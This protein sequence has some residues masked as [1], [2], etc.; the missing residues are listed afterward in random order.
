MKIWSVVIKQETLRQR[1]S[2]K[3][4]KN[5]FAAL[6]LTWTTAEDKDTMRRSSSSVVKAV[7]CFCGLDTHRIRSLCPA[8]NVSCH[9]CGK[10]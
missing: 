7:S 6:D 1:K 5:P 9:I 4:L 2:Q 8:R 10:R 3:S